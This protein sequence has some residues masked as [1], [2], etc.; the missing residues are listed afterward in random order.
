M[1]RRRI[2]NVDR[3]GGFKNP[4]DGTFR[5]GKPRILDIKI[6]IVFEIISRVS[7]RRPGGFKDEN[8]RLENKEG[9]RRE[10]NNKELKDNE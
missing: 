4:E 7:G 8:R 10:K 5:R 2:Q 6:N 9:R 1:A 3:G